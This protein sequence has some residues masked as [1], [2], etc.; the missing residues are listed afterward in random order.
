MAPRRLA[1]NERAWAYRFLVARDGEHCR[2]CKL[3][4]ADLT[5][6]YLD[7]DHVD[8]ND[9][10]WEPEN[11]AL[12]CRSCNVAKQNRA[13]SHTQIGVFPNGPNG[14]RPT[15]FPTARESVGRGRP[16]GGSQS[17]P[18]VE[19]CVCD[20]CV[21]DNTDVRNSP[22]AP[23]SAN[24]RARRGAIDFESGSPEMHANG[25]YEDKA[26]SWLVDLVAAHGEVL[27]RDAI[28]AGAEFVGCSPMT[29]RRYIDKL[30]SLFGPL[31]ETRDAAG[32]VVIVTRFGHQD[33]EVESRPGGV[34]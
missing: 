6:G 3:T 24:M 34:R 21:C 23:G 4:P 5:L 25:L 1:K 16:G 14:A 13:R 7:I 29:I 26:R 12:R 11:L 15:A 18:G 20:R 9:E 31:V 17:S 28:N 30:T 33:G 8:E 27:K 32:R 2:D 22:A 19:T 10:N